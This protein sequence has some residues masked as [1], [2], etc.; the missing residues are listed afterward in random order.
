MNENEIKVF[1]DNSF[2]IIQNYVHPNTDKTIRFGPLSTTLTELF[3]KGYVLRLDSYIGRSFHKI[4]LVYSNDINERY[5]IAKIKNEQFIENR[6]ISLSCYVKEGTSPK[7][8]HTHSANVDYFTELQKKYPVKTK[9][10]ANI[11]NQ[12]ILEYVKQNLK[13][14]NLNRV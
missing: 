14:R 2:L 11:G 13:Q 4:Y 10:I 9:K 6:G 8:C 7:S 5:F 12:T 3:Q 1:E